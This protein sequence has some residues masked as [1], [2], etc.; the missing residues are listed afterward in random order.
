MPYY[1]AYFASRA[2]A[3]AAESVAIANIRADYAAI[4]L[5]DPDIAGGLAVATDAPT[6]R[7]E[8]TSV[9]PLPAGA[10][11]AGT[12]T[13]STVT[14]LV[15]TPDGVPSTSCSIM[16][17]TNAPTVGGVEYHAVGAPLDWQT[18]VAAAGDGRWLV[19]LYTTPLG[20]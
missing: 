6:S 5:L 10:V 8:C 1:R 18:R 19:E 4:A 7:F 2:L 20:S 15:T 12:Q 11:P 14:W 9:T 16:P 3:E 13:Y 17:D